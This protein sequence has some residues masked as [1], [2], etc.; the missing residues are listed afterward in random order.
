MSK[1][2]TTGLLNSDSWICKK[3]G[4]GNHTYSEMCC[5]IVA[6]AEHQDTWLTSCSVQFNNVGTAK[7]TTVYPEMF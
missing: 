3:K 2:S 1:F 7:I 6:D 4:L 5:L